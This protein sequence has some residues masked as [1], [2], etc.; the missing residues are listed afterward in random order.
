MYEVNLS[1]NG[2]NEF[3]SKLKKIEQS[4]NSK[5][6]LTFIAN[7]SFEVLQQV[8]LTN[9]NLDDLN[10][11]EH[12][13]RTNHQYKILDNEI[14]LWNETI[15]DL[16][17]LNLKPETIANYSNGLSLAKIVEY[18]TGIVGASSQASSLAKDW[19]YDVNGH[20]NEGWFYQDNSGQLHFTRG[21]EGRLIFYKTR[22][23]IEK[24]LNSWMKEYISKNLGVE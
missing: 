7:K 13:Y 14:D 12:T 23:E 1:T 19:Q 24:N 20:G 21:I 2:L 3:K 11:Y 6:F 9:L 15:V 5:E 16:D 4:L 10:L 18:G 22:E 17:S 8:T